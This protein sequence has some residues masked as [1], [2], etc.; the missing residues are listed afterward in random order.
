MNTTAK[1]RIETRT[2]YSAGWTT[3]GMGDHNELETASEARCVVRVA[4]RIDES[5]AAA[6]YR[7]QGPDGVESAEMDADAWQL[8]IE[9]LLR[10]LELSNA[11]NG[12]SA[13]VCRID[14]TGAV[15]ADVDDWNK[16][17]EPGKL[18]AILEAIDSE[19]S[20][21][22]IREELASELQAQ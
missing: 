6:E 11:S 22:D 1:Y 17:M 4:R 10:R 7:P 16:P 8:A 14:D 18:C 19:L 9:A 3:D 13:L 20:L 21:G 12:R 5:W 15:L 2:K